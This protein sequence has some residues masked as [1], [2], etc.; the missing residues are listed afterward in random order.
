MSVSADK[1][2]RLW[3]TA[4]IGQAAH[5]GPVRQVIVP[6]AANAIIATG[7]DKQVRLIDPKTGKE[8]RAFAADG[9]V[10]AAALTDGGTKVV[11]T[12][13]KAAQ[14]WAVAD[15]KAVTTIP[16]P[17]PA[18]A[19]AVSPTG[20]RLAI[21]FTEGPANRLR[22]YDGLTGRELQSL[23]DPSGPVRSLA[24]LADNRSVVAAGD[25]KT[26]ALHDA[27]VTGVVSPMPGRAGR[28]IAGGQALTAG[29]TRR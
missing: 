6:N 24:V 22:I 4:L 19:V 10:L 14:V 8:Q 16:L 18:Q 25:D 2:L 27:A 28:R 15:G 1:A 12:G 29:P 13:P 20:A 3:T 9:P 17:G 11:T 21:A 26:V 23:P 5:A 7:D